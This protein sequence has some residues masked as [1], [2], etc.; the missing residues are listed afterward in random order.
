M[1][2]ESTKDATASAAEPKNTETAG[3]PDTEK[4]VP[5]ARFKEIN[6]KLHDLTKAQEAAQEQARQAKEK[7][8][9]EQQKW[10]QLAEQ[11]AAEVESLKPKAALADD[12]SSKLKASILAEIEKWPDEVKAMAP[13]DE[14]PVTAWMDWRDKARPL[15]AQL[16]ETKTPAP[17]NGRGPKPAGQNSKPAAVP[18]LTSRF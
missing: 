2:P 8:L 13:G 14:A 11:R 1:D 12:L 7:E 4:T 15:V 17:G 6:D 10:Q 5:Y 9:A 18:T 3:A 16:V